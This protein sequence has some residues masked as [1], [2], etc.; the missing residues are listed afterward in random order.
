MNSDRI[1]KSIE[2][3]APRARVWRALTSAK[4]FGEWFHVAIDGELTPGG[5]VQGRITEPGYE[6][7]T[8]DLEI[9]QVVPEH[10]FSYRWH[11]YAVDPEVDY[12]AEPATLVEFALAEIEG[13]TRLTV[14]ETGFDRLPP[15]RRAEAFRMNEGGWTAQMSNIERY[16]TP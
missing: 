10:L 6:H 5:R 8:M 3:R 13:G 16:V 14:V 11:P 1:E 2:L 12:S 9:E 7:M 15:E 4:E